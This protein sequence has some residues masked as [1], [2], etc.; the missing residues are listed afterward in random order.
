MMRVVMESAGER[1]AV[2][3]TKLRNTNIVKVFFWSTLGLPGEDFSSTDPRNFQSIRSQIDSTYTLSN[4]QFKQH[5]KSPKKKK[6]LIACKSLQLF[7]LN[8]YFL[9]QNRIVG[10]FLYIAV[11]RAQYLYLTITLQSDSR[12]IIRV[13]S[14]IQN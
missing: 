6:S 3:E 9:L 7:L 10:V 4:M 13:S 5:N 8:I 1:K 11:H 2:V 14:R 12:F